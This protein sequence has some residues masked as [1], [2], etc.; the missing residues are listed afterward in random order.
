MHAN[1]RSVADL[2]AGI[3]ESVVA[4]VPAIDIHT[5]IRPRAPSADDLGDVLFYHYIVAELAASGVERERIER[6]VSAADRIVLFTAE[7]HRISNT[8]TSWCLRRV[9]SALGMDAEAELTVDA[10]TALD[11]HF[12][13][14]STSPGWTGELLRDRH[15]IR[16]TFLTLNIN[17][18]LPEFD[19]T[20][21]AGTLR[22]DDLIAGLSAANLNSLETLAG[23]SIGSPADFERAAGERLSAFAAAGGVAVTAGM[24]PEEDFALE[25]RAEVEKLFATVR[26]GGVLEEQDRARLH[27]YLLGVFVNLAADLRLPVQLLLGVRRPLPGDAAVPVVR[28]DL[29]ARFAPLFHKHSA[30][31]FDLL[32]ASVAHSQELI[33]VAKNYPN[34]SLSGHWWYAFSPPYIRGMLTERLLALPAAKLHGFF[35]DAYNIE[36]SAG[37]LALFRREFARVLAELIISGYL[38][39]SQAPEIARGLLYENPLRFYGIDAEGPAPSPRHRQ[40]SQVPR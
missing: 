23:I 1:N 17:D 12:R 32:L 7:Q 4:Q 27:S 20:L 21:F 5:H 31:R 25:T 6:A 9:L 15:K 37:K 19:R 18:D 29:S 26:G 24:P 14:H 36:W 2:T 39:E 28:A 3:L 40:A 22:L 8:V 33:A 38:T 10:L 34:V 11:R 35:S 16:R 30:V 13:E